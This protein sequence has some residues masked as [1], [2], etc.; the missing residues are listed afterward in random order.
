MYTT[1]FEDLRQKVLTG[2][3]DLSELIPTSVEVCKEAAEQC[4]IA[5]EGLARFANRIDLQNKV[6]DIGNGSAIIQWLFGCQNRVKEIIAEKRNMMNSVNS[7]KSDVKGVVTPSIQPPQPPQPQPHSHIQPQPQPQQQAQPTNPMNCSNV[8]CD[9]LYNRFV[10][11][12]KSSQSLYKEYSELKSTTQKDSTSSSELKAEISRLKDLLSNQRHSSDAQHREMEQKRLESESKVTSLENSLR[13]KE[14]MIH[15]LKDSIKRLEAQHLEQTVAL[16]RTRDELTQVQTQT[17]TQTRP[18]YEGMKSDLSE[19]DYYNEAQ[20]HPKRPCYGVAAANAAGI[21][22]WENEDNNNNNNNNNTTTD[23]PKANGFVSAT[24]KLL[25]ERKEKGLNGTGLNQSSAPP[26]STSASTAVPPRRVVK[27][28]TPY[29]A[30]KNSLAQNAQGNVAKGAIQ[31]S[32]A[33]SAVKKAFGE[34]SPANTADDAPKTGPGGI[35]L[36]ENGKM[37][38]RLAACEPALVEIILNEM[39]DGSP[40]V[41][42]DDIAGLEFAKKNVIEIVV[43]PMLR[44]DLFRGLRGPPKGMMLFGPPGTGKVR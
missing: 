44:P 30:K 35:P 27:F 39:L 16:T 10:A 13:N 22:A 38:G 40:G 33:P 26:Q 19:R 41:R 17:L 5:M 29:E 1:E 8:G 20:T 12:T 14:E 21:G 31:S 15:A 23:L 11:L 43:W 36:D 42:W 24:F 18:N 6:V 37:P 32:N 3:Q 7:V 9:T 34:G 25:Q 28:V 4:R 2:I